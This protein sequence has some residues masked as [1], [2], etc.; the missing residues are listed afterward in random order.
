M[1]VP[2]SRVREAL[3]AVLR[4]E[5]V[6]ALE[7]DELRVD[8]P[9]VLQDGRLL[10][11]YLRWCGEHGGFIA[12]DGGYA[13]GQ[14]EA[15]VRSAA[16][17]RERYAELKGIAR[18]LD[19]EWDGAEFRFCA[20][21]LETVAR[22]TAVLARAVDRALTLI[23]TRTRPTTAPLHARLLAE[24]RQAGLSVVHRA[25]IVIPPLPEVTVDFRLYRNHSEAAV[26]MLAAR[27]ERGA[28][29]AIDRAVSSF[30][31][32][33]RGKYPGLLVA[34]YDEE[35]ATAATPLLDRFRSAAPERTLLLPSH[36]AVHGIVRRLAA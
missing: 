30:H 5:V 4:E 6:C 18:G 22:R 23:P 33:S 9:Y 16:A 34:V 32:L 11:V 14:I 24:F 17:L 13:T 27:T 15:F 3:V 28:A 1:L 19:I 36:D 12:S 35:G 21:D 31:L 29:I 7:N 10:R 20:P 8:T 25:T 26:E 2:P